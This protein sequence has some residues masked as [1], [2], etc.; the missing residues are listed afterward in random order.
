MAIDTTQLQGFSYIRDNG[1]NKYLVEQYLLP[2]LA[3]QSRLG[4]GSRGIPLPTPFDKPQEF[5]PLEDAANLVLSWLEDNNHLYSKDKSQLIK[6]MRKVSYE[7]FA[8]I[9]GEIYQDRIKDPNKLFTTARQQNLAEYR[10][11]QK[12]NTPSTPSKFDP[13][14]AIDDY[15]T[16]YSQ[17]LRAANLGTSPALFQKILPDGVPTGGR[18]LS[19]QV[20][21]QIILQNISE[22]RGAAHAH[23][24]DEPAAQL[25]VSRKLG[26]IIGD[27]YPEQ[28]PYLNLLGDKEISANLN[29]FTQNIEDQ[30]ERDGVT[31]PEI[32]DSKNHALAAI[33]DT[34]STEYEIYQQIQR[35]VP[36]TS[37]AEKKIFAKALIQTI[38][39]TAN[40]QLTG[41]EIIELAG[42][43]I[44]ADTTQLQAIKAE[45]HKSGL[46][47][48]IEYRQNELT[49]IVDSH[50]LTLGE[51]NLLRRGINPFKTSRS[52]VDLT[53]EKDKLLNEF[54]IDSGTKFA[55]IEEAHTFE[56]GRNNPDI[57]WIRRFRAHEDQL[58]AYSF[59]E[60][61]EKSLI[62]RTRFGRWVT[63]TRSRLYNLQDKFFNKWVDIEDTITGRKYINKLF[64]SW[65]KFA[66]GFTVKFGKTQVPIFRIVPWL[67]DRLDEWKKLTTLKAISTTSK[68]RGP[69]GKL[70]HWSLK[71]YKLGDHTVDGATY[72]VFRSAWGAGTKWVLKKSV[73]L[74][75]KLGLGSAFKYATV[76]AS[77]TAIRLLLQMGGKALAK[78]GIKAIAALV[79]AGTF[80]G[81]IFSGV[82]AVLMI[83]D[84]VKLAWNF[85]KNF[86][87]NGEFRKTVIKWGAA[88]AAFFGAINFAS[89]GIAISLVFLWT[90]Q[91]LLLSFAIVGIMMA[92][93]ALVSRAFN[94]TIHLDSET[95][96]EIPLVDGCIQ[97]APVSGP[98]MQGPHTDPVTGSHSKI[99]ALDIYVPDG[100][101]VKSAN[102]GRVIFTGDAAQYGLRVDIQTQF[103][104]KTATFIY[105]HLGSIAVNNGQEVAAGQVVG[106]SDSTSSIPGYQNPHLHFEMAG[107]ITEYAQCPIPGTN[108]STL[109]GCNGVTDCNAT[110]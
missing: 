51:R 89:I 8:T 4:K 93:I 7:Q 70:I 23:I 43:R 101:P 21:A 31:L 74:A 44:H 13:G 33:G 95:A 68:W 69:L 41:D 52:E 62:N 73:V 84:L 25:A 83:F 109:E 71:Q 36:L 88:I 90:L 76:S 49:V 104:G 54:Q 72:Q 10:E 17:L 65:D 78:L 79:A 26:Q 14:K 59:L 38:S 86:L 22:L 58:G 40:R 108:P 110:I 103:E 98:I 100:T 102:A 28:S 66:E 47:F 12:K 20:L 11:A 96:P 30:L 35:L 18:D 42:S 29:K 6:L 107:D 50:H 97:V 91:T 1:V 2:G 15:N 37:D 60:F 64:D 45:L 56:Q 34:V 3:V 81:S 94:D 53:I 87:T 67:Y 80:I 85:V 19:K 63:N 9:A 61:N 99:V 55:S 39:A 48:A 105:G 57:N 46:A 82:L 77:R 24:G 32:D 75:T 106:R 92:S 5:I 27:S 16:L